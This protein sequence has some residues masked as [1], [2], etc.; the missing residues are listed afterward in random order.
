MRGRSLHSVADG[1]ILVQQRGD[2]HRI[3]RLLERTDEGYVVAWDDE[4]SPTTMRMLPLS[5]ARVPEG[6]LRHRA[7]IDLPG[8]AADLASSPEQVFLELLRER[9]TALRSQEL[10]KSLV[11]LG[12]DSKAVSAA[13][14]K[15]KPKLGK[16]A[17]VQQG[18][19]P[20]TYQWSD[21]AIDPHAA[22]RALPTPFLLDQLT[23]AGTTD[24]ERQIA[25]ERLQQQTDTP[26]AHRLGGAA[27]RLLSWPTVEDVAA[28]RAQPL[29]SGA[30]LADLSDKVLSAIADTAASDDRR[31]ILW[32]LAAATRPARPLSRLADRL[33]EDPAADTEITDM[34]AGLSAAI[35][36]AAATDQARHAQTASVVIARIAPLIT[37]TER[38]AA[39]LALL[40]RAP[41][42]SQQGR[43]LAESLLAVLPDLDRRTL[44]EAL[45]DGSGSVLAAAAASPLASGSGRAALLAA[46]ADRDPPAIRDAASWEGVTADQLAALYEKNALP[47]LLN[48]QDIV[49]EVVSPR[50]QA[51]AAAA[52]MRSDLAKILSWPAPLLRLLPPDQLAAAT[53]R[54]AE[55]DPLTR[56][57][58]SHLNDRSSLLALQHELTIA[59]E[60][61]AA[62]RD[63]LERT[64]DDLAATRRGVE[65]L[66]ERLRDQQV[67]AHAASDAQRR[68]LR[69]E[70]LRAAVDVLAEL[71][72]HGPD[73]EATRHVRD[74]LLAAA[75]R[76][77]IH[78]IGVVGEQV[79]Y[80]RTQHELLA[81]EEQ[82]T[83]YVVRPGY[84]WRHGMTT[85][86]LQRAIVSTTRT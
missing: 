79:S 51:A 28:G 57:L 61:A 77:G 35:V 20:P 68:Q 42:R 25:R 33:A 26:L 67:S 7:L 37:T 82:P 10:V 83:V 36:G 45:P 60:D 8:L 63:E 76:H 31:D 5:V 17:H 84:T 54:V 30:A 12:I 23:A 62:S 47:A 64:R 2:G 65:S 6:S 70:G 46:A 32:L 19:P 74:Q 14:K 73:D 29:D 85:T 86:V 71:D 55:N 44:A 40:T 75:A 11:E 58:L 78:P 34:F 21:H 49:D 15:A 41:I 22:L 80:D 43:E 4:P 72:R 27:L 1:D 9:R 59:R 38:V 56:D 39:S 50:V 53:R 18:G 24:D 48:R 69:I 66:E 81:G 13:W 16:H 52:R 3:G